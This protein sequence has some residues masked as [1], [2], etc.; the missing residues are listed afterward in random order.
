MPSSSFIIIKM[1]RKLFQNSKKPIT[2]QTNN[3]ILHS[4]KIKDYTLLFG[5]ILLFGIGVYT[6]LW[7]P[8]DERCSEELRGTTVGP[9]IP[10]TTRTRWATAPLC[11]LSLGLMFDPSWCQH[12][13]VWIPL[14]LGESLLL[15]TSD[16]CKQWEIQELK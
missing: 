13:K 12:W 16:P 2:K 6:V 11:H 4:G 9:M 10:I 7:E 5:I 14:D 3:G 15:P 8:E 1:Q